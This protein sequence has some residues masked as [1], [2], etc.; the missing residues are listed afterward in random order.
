MPIDPTEPESVEELLERPP[1]EEAPEE[2][3]AE[4]RT[5]VRRDRDEPPGVRSAESADPADV[6]EQSRV[7]ELDEEDYR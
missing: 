1:G 2:D 5:E 7:V 6:V 4:Q 3:A